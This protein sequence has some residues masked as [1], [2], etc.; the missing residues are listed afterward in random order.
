MW[1]GIGIND[2]EGKW[3]GIIGF[4]VCAEVIT[5][6]GSRYADRSGTHYNTINDTTLLAQYFRKLSDCII[7][8]DVHFQ[9]SIGMA[10][11]E[12]TEM[13]AGG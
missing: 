10:E 13:D 11:D 8:V 1:R 5:F 4:T 7:E 12:G 9:N 6:D 2:D 3:E